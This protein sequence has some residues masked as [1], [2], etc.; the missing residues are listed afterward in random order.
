M[1]LNKVAE[2]EVAAGPDKVVVAEVSKVVEIKPVRRAVRASTSFS[3]KPTRT[4]T[5]HFPATSL[6]H[7]SNPIARHV[8]VDAEDKA[9]EAVVEAAQAAAIKAEITARHPRRTINKRPQQGE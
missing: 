5:A 8:P 9:A 2:V 3:T 4:K 6:R 7:S 1:D